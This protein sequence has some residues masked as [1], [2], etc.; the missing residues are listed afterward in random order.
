MPVVASHCGQAV[1]MRI[2]LCARLSYAAI[3]AFV[4][5]RSRA[6]SPYQRATRES[7]KPNFALEPLRFAFDVK[8]PKVT[9]ILTFVVLMLTATI[10]MPI[11]SRAEPMRVLVLGVIDGESFNAIDQE[12]ARHRYE[13]KRSSHRLAANP[14]QPN[15]APISTN[16]SRAMPCAS[17]PTMAIA[18]GV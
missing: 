17:M 12:D 13:S 1:W 7:C 9:R 14:A 16:L 2:C 6:G 18:R 10:T 5:R 4:P 11:A 15:R 8:T 3:V